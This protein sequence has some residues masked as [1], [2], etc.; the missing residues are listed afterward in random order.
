MRHCKFLQWGSEK[1]M[2]S[3]APNWREDGGGAKVIC[4]NAGSIS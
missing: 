4:W 2:I 3:T 1:S